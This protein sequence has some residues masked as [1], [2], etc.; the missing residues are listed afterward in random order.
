MKRSGGVDQL[1]KEKEGKNDNRKEGRAE[2]MRGEGRVGW[3]KESVKGR[4]EDEK[5]T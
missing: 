1:M 2:G 5:T 4:T 3:K